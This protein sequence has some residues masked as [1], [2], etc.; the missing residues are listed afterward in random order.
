[1]RGADK[2]GSSNYAEKAAWWREAVERLAKEV[3]EETAIKIMESCGRKCCGPT[4]I[5]HAKKLMNESK[6]L[7]ELLG[8]LNKIRIG[9]GRLR[10]KN[11][12]TVVGGYDR[13]YCGQVKQT[14][15][16]FSNRIYCH[17]SVGW[18][19][20]LFESALGRPIQIEIQQSI[21]SGAESCEFIIHI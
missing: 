1:M 14:K 13:C 6:S 15:K 20:Q 3:G 16:P 19:K 4:R 9:G 12:N 21:I 8:R 7:E 17:C 2:Y 5:K 18:Y 11:Q 10:L